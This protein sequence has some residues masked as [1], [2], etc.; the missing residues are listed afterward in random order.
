[1]AN[2]EIGALTD[3]GPIAGREK[4]HAVNDAGNSRQYELNDII[5]SR[6][7]V[8]LCYITPIANSATLD[9]RGIRTQ[10][11]DATAAGAKT[12]ASTGWLASARRAGYSSGAVANKSAGFF[13][14]NSHFWRGNAD[15]R[16][17]FDIEMSYGL[18]SLNAAAQTRFFCGL[19]GEV[20]PNDLEVSNIVNM[21]GIGCDLADNNLQFMVNDATGAATKT[22]LG[23]LFAGK[24]AGAAYSLRLHSE[25]NGVSIDYWVRRIDGGNEAEVSGSIAS[26][27]PANTVFL[28]P[29][30]YNN[31]GAGGGTAVETSLIGFAGK[32]GL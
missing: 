6:R 8:D 25:P 12:I 13:G 11:I 14:L 20:T 23:A 26:N 16:G 27:I 32:A 18:E 29:C 28:G 1:M 9:Q 30:L 3:G 19:M 31:N 5:L 10:A 22:D 21:I 15:A 4:F 2:K 7:D 17:G 24:T